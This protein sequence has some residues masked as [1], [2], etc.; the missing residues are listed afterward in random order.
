LLGNF[1]LTPTRL[2]ESIN[3]MTLFKTELG[4]VLRHRQSNDCSTWSNDKIPSTSFY[5]WFLK[6]ILI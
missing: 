1:F 5:R 4:V 6:N 3:L 2:V